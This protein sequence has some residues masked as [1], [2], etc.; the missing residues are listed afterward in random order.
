MTTGTLIH[1]FAFIRIPVRGSVELVYETVISE[2]LS[3]RVYSSLIPTTSAVRDCGED[4]IR[5]CHVFYGKD[6]TFGR[7]VGTQKR[8]NRIQT[9]KKNLL[10]RIADL[11]REEPKVCPVCFGPMVLRKG[12]FGKF[13]GCVEYPKCK[14]TRNVEQ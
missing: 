6:K 14:G 5:V 11:L 7:I 12:N 2:E 4:A 3:I 10:S 9:W 13:F 1:G 8:V